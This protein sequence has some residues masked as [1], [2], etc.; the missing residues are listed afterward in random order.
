MP[1]K[2]IKQGDL[3]DP[4]RAQITDSGVPVD[5]TN[6]QDVNFEMGGL[7]DG[8]VVIESLQDGIVRYEW[9]EGDTDVAGL[10]RAQ[11][12]VTLESGKPVTYPE[13][14]YIEVLIMEG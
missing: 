7:V 1:D 3:G 14:G 13:E 6:A 5:L 2:T 11:F 10:F 8:D 12:E 4:I 9:Q